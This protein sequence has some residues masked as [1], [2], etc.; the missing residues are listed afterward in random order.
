M[1]QVLFGNQ[2][3]VL[4]LDASNYAVS[5]W[6]VNYSGEDYHGGGKFRNSTVALAAG[7][8]GFDDDAIEINAG[9]AKVKVLLT[10]NYTRAR[11]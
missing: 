2:C 5:T 7:G 6:A 9:K 1:A 3:R 4:G 10:V 11:L 8:G